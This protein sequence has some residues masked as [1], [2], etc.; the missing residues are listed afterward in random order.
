MNIPHR[1]D[2]KEAARHLTEKGFKTSPATLQKYA[3][4]GGGPD[5]QIFGNRAVYT[6]QS[7]AD[8]IEAKLSA[9]R[10]HTSEAA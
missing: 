2:R 9:P 3:T 6:E 1:F 7:L 8:W 5:Y 10:R 4:L